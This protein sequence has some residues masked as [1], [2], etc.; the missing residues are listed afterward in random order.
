MKVYVKQSIYNTKIRSFEEGYF[1]F[2]KST[3]KHKKLKEFTECLGGGIHAL[4]SIGCKYYWFEGLTNQEW[5]RGG[6]FNQP[7]INPSFDL[8]RNPHG[9]CDGK[10][11]YLLR[12]VRKEKPLKINEY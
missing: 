8:F 6:F 4:N 9:F 2:E 5:Y 3:A 1:V 11:V 7:I 12:E 10:N